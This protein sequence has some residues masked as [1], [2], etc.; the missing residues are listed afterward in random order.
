V[1]VFIAD[2]TSKDEPAPA[3]SENVQHE[4]LPEAYLTV[5]R[6]TS[7]S[8]TAL[9][10]PFQTPGILRRGRSVAHELTDGSYRRKTPKN[11]RNSLILRRF[12]PDEWLEFTLPGYFISKVTKE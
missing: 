12:S 3:V 6:R 1:S 5:D 2:A 11:V 9:E 7:E 10:C 8:S 4:P